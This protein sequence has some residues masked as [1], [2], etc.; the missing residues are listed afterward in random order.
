M[1]TLVP[2]LLAGVVV[3]MSLLVALR[4]VFGF[5]QYL[6]TRK[7]EP[8]EPAPVINPPEPVIRTAGVELVAWLAILWAVASLAILIVVGMSLQDHPMLASAV[9]QLS[10]VL[11]AVYALVAIVLIAWGGAMLLKQMAY[12]RR[13]LAWGV[14]LLGI[15]NVFL[16]AFC[17]FLRQFR[18][19]PPD[20]RRWMIPVAVVLAVHTLIGSAVGVGAQHVGLPALSG[21]D[22][23][24]DA[25]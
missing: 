21:T 25:R 8:F 9:V 10:L 3:L 17:L 5:R 12:G 24:G 13:W 14:A 1:P 11:Y 18:D 16:F 15:M 23:S 7:P 2:A 22:A 6:R 19:T 4:L 20:V